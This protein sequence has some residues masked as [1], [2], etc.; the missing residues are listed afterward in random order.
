LI[1]IMVKKGPLSK[2]VQGFSAIKA[3]ETEP[4]TDPARAELK[5][6]QLLLDIFSDSFNEVLSSPN[7]NSLLQQVKQALFNR[8]FATAFGTEDCL[9]VYASRWSPT[10][11]LG[12]ASIL[13]GLKVY[14]EPLTNNL[15]EGGDAP[16][17]MR[18]LRMVAVGGAAAEIVALAASI[19]SLGTGPGSIVLIDSGPWDQVIAKLY[20]GLTTPPPLS[21]YASAAAK[22][23]NT[24]LIDQSAFSQAFIHRDILTLSK[25]ELAEQLGSDSLILTLLFTLNELYTSGG[26]GKTT[27]FLL[28]LTATIPTGSL[29]LVVDSPGSYSETAVGNESKRY[30]MQWLLDHTLLNNAGRDQKDGSCVWEKLESYDSQWFR[31]SKALLYPIPLEDMRYQ[32]HLY[33]AT[34]PAD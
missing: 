8:D 18:S 26:I 33:R 4:F 3:A 25:E 5:R 20:T 11:A 9:E 24:A 1:E 28:S 10:R 27:A 31:L 17:G 6:Q 13:D 7:F 32:M 30:P 22:A 12:Y 2:P 14:L 15:Q 29:L 19:Q 16:E 23:A 34:R 21:K